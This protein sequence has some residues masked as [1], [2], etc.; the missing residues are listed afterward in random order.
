MPVLLTLGLIGAVAFFALAARARRKGVLAQLAQHLG[1][2]AGSND[3][4]GTHEGVAVHLQFATR[5]SGSSQTQ[6][7]YVDCPLPPGYPLTIH[8]E[9][10]GWFDR[11]KIERGTMVDVEVGDAAFDEKFRVEAAPAEVVRQIL[12]PPVCAYLMAARQAELTT[13]D[14]ALRLA[15]RGWLDQLDPAR[16]AIATAV[17]IAR[18]VRPAHA[19]ADAAVARPIVGGAYR[20][21]ADESPVR[22]AQSARADEVARVEAL[23]RQRSATQTLIWT[24]IVLGVGVAI[25]VAIASE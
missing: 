21:F 8:L 3:V 23:R 18:G 7:T 22:E 13:S 5:G 20:G 9:E 12:T 15:Q 10:H 17:T 16:A 24:L 19:A 25:A 14:G 2:T 11:G 1:G 6:W 4:R